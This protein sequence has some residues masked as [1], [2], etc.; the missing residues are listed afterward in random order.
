MRKV[1]ALAAAVLLMVS[2]V[3]AAVPPGGQEGGNVGTQDGTQD[4]TNFPDDLT[5]TDSDR[6][7][8]GLNGTDA[9]DRHITAT[10]DAV[11]VSTGNFF[12]KVSDGQVIWN[13]SGPGQYSDEFGGGDPV[14]IDGVAYIGLR[15]V[16]GDGIYKLVGYNTSTGNRVSVKDVDMT[17]SSDYEALMG[18]VVM[19]GDIYINSFDSSGLTRYDPQNN[20]TETI[21]NSTSSNT[22][23]YKLGANDKYIWGGNSTDYPSNVMYY[24]VEND[25]FNEANMEG[26]DSY[27]MG[28]TTIGDTAVYQAPN[29][30]YIF[31]YNM[32]TD[33][34][35]WNYTVDEVKKNSTLSNSRFSGYFTAGPDGD[36]YH[37]ATAWNGDNRTYFTRFDP[38]SGQIE[39]TLTAGEINDTLSGNSFLETAPIDPVVEDDGTMHIY[40]HQYNYWEISPNGTIE[41]SFYMGDEELPNTWYSHVQPATR[42]VGNKSTY[43]AFAY[44][45]KTLEGHNYELVAIKTDEGHWRNGPYDGVSERSFFQQSVNNTNNTNDTPT[46]FTGGTS[47]PILPSFVGTLGPV[48]FWVLGAGGL[49]GVGGIVLYMRRQD[50]MYIE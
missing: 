50:M 34:V 48:P 47:N 14:V 23:F 17:A 32:S 40:S 20:T 36:L 27:Y 19:D 5:T 33:S 45:N 24:D 6:W 44:T 26:V 13:K 28:L 10:K 39:W 4:G 22:E 49:L 7:T 31:G 18:A 15:N 9:Y 11:Y 37:T 21:L 30:K 35:D 3:G 1:L 46:N 16:T 12:Y 38:D 43:F 2:G 8:A 41:E 29:D 25:T 42:Q